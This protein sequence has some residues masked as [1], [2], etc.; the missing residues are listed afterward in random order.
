M[1]AAAQTATGVAATSLTPALEI[2]GSRTI[3]IPSKDPTATVTVPA[4]VVQPL[5]SPPPDDIR[6]ID[7]VI[8]GRA[9]GAM[10]AFGATLT[11]HAR[12]RLADIVITVDLAKLPRA[13]TYIVKLYP[14]RG[15]AVAGSAFE[16]SLVRPIA[17]LQVA[18]SPL[19]IEIVQRPWGWTTQ[20]AILDISEK[21][22]VGGLAGLRAA[23]TTGLKGPGDAVVN[24]QVDV[25]VPPTLAEGT[26]VQVPVRLVGDYGAI[27]LGTSKG[28]VTLTSPSLAQPLILPVEVVTRRWLGWLV[29]ALGTGIVAGYLVRQYLESRQVLVR[30]Q[31][32]T[33]QRLERL[34]QLVRGQTDVTARTQLEEI[35]AQ[36][37]RALQEEQAADALDKATATATAATDKALSDVKD[38]RD[39]LSLRVQ[40]LRAKVTAPEPQP[41]AVQRVLADLSDQLRLRD[42]ELKAG[43]ITDVERD[44]DELDRALL[45]RVGDALEPWRQSVLMLKAIGEWAPDSGLARAKDKA[46]AL[47]A[48]VDNEASIDGK[49]S[50]SAEVGTVLRRQLYGAGLQ[51]VGTALN[52]ALAKLTAPA[53]VQSKEAIEAL[54]RGEITIDHV[55]DVAATIANARAALTTALDTHPPTERHAFDEAIKAGRFEAAAELL[56]EP[57]MPGHEG[58][59]AFRRQA[60]PQESRRDREAEG[61]A[62]GAQARAAW[63]LTIQAPGDVVVGAPITLI[64]ESSRPFPVDAVA[65]WSAGGRV[66]SEGDAGSR[67][68]RYTPTEAG[69]TLIE[70]VVGDAMGERAAAQKWIDVRRVEG[71][72][73]AAT[74]A[75]RHT[76]LSVTQSTIVGAILIGAGVIIF[77]GTWLGGIE[78][79]FSAFLWGFSVDIGVAK[80]R[81]LAAPVVG[82]AMPVT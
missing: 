37:R 71:L 77:R 30:A 82:R 61:V 81:E 13:G 34:T 20:P 74:L 60:A 6:I 68:F 12:S 16:I 42:A 25:G 15:G 31:R 22:R 18:L 51:T 35:A 63:A 79:L 70:V 7:V 17:E 8:D 32:D 26:Q 2:L 78:D 57:S 21:T 9:G 75:K 66:I 43:L 4:V 52:A 41:T 46:L 45:R 53:L 10:M 44:L 80:I 50:K 76:V 54:E 47:A 19:R 5:V 40:A 14:L 49:L 73:S 33:V 39:K 29:A 11:S 65:R 56:P 27:P 72:E 23:T 62:I 55:A 59:T 48:A 58:F 28:V 38:K 67:L 69:S 1:P 36:L 24:V 64:I 3:E